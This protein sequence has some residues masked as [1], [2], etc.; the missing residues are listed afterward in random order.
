V[1]AHA[2]RANLHTE[3]LITAI[4]KA[5]TKS[6]EVSGCVAYLAQDPGQ[7]TPLS[8]LGEATG[9]DFQAGAVQQSSAAVAVVSAGS[10]ENGGAGVY[11]QFAPAMY[12]PAAVATYPLTPGIGNGYGGAMLLKPGAFSARAAQTR[13]VGRPVGRSP[14]HPP[15]HPPITTFLP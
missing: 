4:Y 7:K 1:F 3:S 10:S 12:A 8:R 15:T 13:Y 5:C 9:Y 14:S 2:V 6:G 11:V